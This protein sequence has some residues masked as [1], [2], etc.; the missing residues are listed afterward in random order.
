MVTEL[1]LLSPAPSIYGGTDQI[2]RNIIG[3]RVLGLP[4]KPEPI[5]TPPSPSFPRTAE[6][7]PMG[8]QAIGVAGWDLRGKG[9]RGHRCRPRHRP[10]SRHRVRPA[11]GQGRRQRPRCRGGRQRVLRGPGRRGGRG[12]PRLRGRGGGQRRGRQRLGGRQAIDRH[13]RRHLR[14]SR[15]PGQ[16]RRNPAGPDAGEHDRHRVGCRH[17]GPPAR[18]LRSHALGRRV[19]ARAG[20]GRRVQRRPHHQHHLAVGHLRQRGPDQLRGGQGRHRVDD[21]D[22]RR[23]SSVGTGSPSTPSLPPR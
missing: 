20:Q 19:L 13:G 4:R 11:G 14:R 3:E 22:R 1:A 21:G 17:P 7:Q 9:R 6:G 8:D 2:Q 23:W 5:A 10:G 16:Q 15:R 12:D 18:H